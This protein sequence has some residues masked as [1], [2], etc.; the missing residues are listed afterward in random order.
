MCH[1]TPTCSDR[2]IF[3]HS[4]VQ[5]S[6]DLSGSLFVSLPA[7]CCGG[8][9]HESSPAPSRRANRGR[10][11]CPAFRLHSDGEENTSLTERE[12]STARPHIGDLAC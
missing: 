9:L 4:S 7:L 2:L 12:G 5:M 1:T 10:V 11:N 3:H 6:S 8:C